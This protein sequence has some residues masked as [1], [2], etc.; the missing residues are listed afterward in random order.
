[1]MKGWKNITVFLVLIMF[2]CASSREAISLVPQEAKINQRKINKDRE[3]KARESRKQ[4][5]KAVKQHM[6]NQS[7]ATKKMMK[8]AKRDAKK[9]TPLK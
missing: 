4:Y 7:K 9:N 3:K 6:D 8:K 2:L 1:M 5:E